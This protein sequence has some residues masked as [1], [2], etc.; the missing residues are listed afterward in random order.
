MHA[1]KMGPL[2]IKRDLVFFRRRL[3][4]LSLLIAALDNAEHKYEIV[5]LS[6]ILKL[7]GASFEFFS[8]STRRLVGSLTTV[9]LWAWSKYLLS[10]SEYHDQNKN[11]EPHR[12]AK[13]YIRICILDNYGNQFDQ[14][15]IKIYYLKILWKPLNNRRFL[16]YCSKDELNWLKLQ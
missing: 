12:C 3:M 13:Q 2:T 6:S 9:G 16:H 14:H 15:E 10:S 8:H 5:L 7:S 11:C 4:N 1:G